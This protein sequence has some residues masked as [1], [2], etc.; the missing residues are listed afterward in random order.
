MVVAAGGAFETAIE[1]IRM[2]QGLLLC[3]QREQ[4]Q[5]LGLVWVVEGES[6][7]GC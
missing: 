2:R 5:G 6:T 3:V 4:A 7:E 1:A